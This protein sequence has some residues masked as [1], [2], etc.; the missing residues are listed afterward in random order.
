[1]AWNMSP[2]LPLSSLVH[3]GLY[4][5]ITMYTTI[6]L[7]VRKA[8]ADQRILD[9]TREPACITQ[10]STTVQYLHIRSHI[11]SVLRYSYWCY[12]CCILLTGGA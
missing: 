3:S 5:T 7:V 12:L 1:M 4:N 11:L 8:L 6:W 9:Q 10:S 2:T